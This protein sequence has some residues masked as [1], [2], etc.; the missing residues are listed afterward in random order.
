MEQ[1]E[2]LA[3]EFQSLFDLEIELPDA[4]REAEARIAEGI[5]AVIEE[6]WGNG[7]HPGI[8]P[9]MVYD[10]IRYAVRAR[11]LAGDAGALEI[12]IGEVGARWDIDEF[13][14]IPVDLTG[15][16]MYSTLSVEADQRL[17]PKLDRI[18]S[19]LQQY[20]QSGYRRMETH[21]VAELLRVEHRL[22]IDL[23]ADVR[24]A[25]KDPAGTHVGLYCLLPNGQAMYLLDPLD[26]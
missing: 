10:G 22:A 21:V 15:S 11:D 7:E 9:S 5:P 19:A 4:C 23:Y 13:V 6:A 26:G 8:K 24:A 18:S 17:G 12:A 25:V 20:L 14:R 1:G 3:L 2:K 16:C